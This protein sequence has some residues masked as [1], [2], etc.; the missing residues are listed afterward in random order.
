MVAFEK[1]LAQIARFVKL[2]D[3]P[4]AAPLSNPTG[5]AVETTDT[6]SPPGPGTRGGLVSS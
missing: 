1:Y 3:E 6:T 4:I 2:D 5:K